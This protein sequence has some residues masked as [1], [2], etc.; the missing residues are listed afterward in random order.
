MAN[1]QNIL[2]KN[3]L[4]VCMGCIA[5]WLVG[6]AFAYGTT[7]YPECTDQDEDDFDPES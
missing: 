7:T 2:M 4:D 6:Y 3:L 5:F 1:V